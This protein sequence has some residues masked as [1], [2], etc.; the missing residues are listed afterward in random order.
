MLEQ[1]QIQKKI[2]SALSSLTS[3]KKLSFVMFLILM[4]LVRTTF[5]D[6]SNAS[7]LTSM[8]QSAQ[9]KKNANEPWE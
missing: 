2:L 1:K 7:R 5:Y 3:K 9:I 4:P 8:A 6:V